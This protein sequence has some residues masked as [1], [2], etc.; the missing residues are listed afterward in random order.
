MKLV[1]C[2]KEV[3]LDIWGVQIILYKFWPFLIR[4]VTYGKGTRADQI[5]RYK[6]YKMRSRLWLKARKE[7]QVG[8]QGVHEGVQPQGGEQVSAP[9]SR[10]EVHHVSQ[11][12]DGI[13]PPTSIGVESHVPGGCQCGDKNVG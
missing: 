12:A 5:S 9:R 2:S 11:G 7:E 13:E 6:E 4:K 8:Q 1:N 10:G 3:R